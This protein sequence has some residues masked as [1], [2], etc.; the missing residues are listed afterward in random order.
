MGLVEFPVDSGF[1]LRG[2]RNDGAIHCA[3]APHILL[4]DSPYRRSGTK[5]DSQGRKPET[6]TAG[7]RVARSR[8]IYH[9]IPGWRL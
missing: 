3:I 7:R 1:P 5:A 4:P 9:W 2:P 8:G 6:P